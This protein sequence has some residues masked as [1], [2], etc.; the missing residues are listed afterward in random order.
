[1]VVNLEMPDGAS[2]ERTEKVMERLAA[3]C[4]ETDG[5]GHTVQI[6]GYSIFTGANIPNNGG[7][8]VPLKP[9]DQRKGRH[10]DDIMRDLNAKFAAVTEGRASAFGAP[11]ILGLG[12]AGG[13]KLQVL[14]QGNLGYETL[15]GMTWNLAGEVTR[16]DPGGRP[17][18]I[19]AAFSSF[20]S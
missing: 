9:F 8:Y 2:L 18:G 20:R 4:L 1:L 16:P 13:F 14:D 5:V 10:A 3:M 12:N 19:S 6:S 7:M 15:E 11:P 17:S